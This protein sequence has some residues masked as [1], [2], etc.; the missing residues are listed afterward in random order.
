MLCFMMFWLMIYKTF[1]FNNKKT[2]LKFRRFSYKN[3]TKSVIFHF[4]STFLMFWRNNNQIW[5]IVLAILFFLCLFWSFEG[6]ILN[7]LISSKVFCSTVV[8][9]SIKLFTPR[10]KHTKMCRVSA[11][12]TFKN[13]PFDIIFQMSS[14]V[15]VV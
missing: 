5:E 13:S 2:A 8:L 9:Q 14:P 12:Y 6:I 1:S 10:K 11:F 3:F 4:F 15:L 7:K